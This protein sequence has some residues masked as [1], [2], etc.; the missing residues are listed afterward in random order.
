M[1]LLFTHQNSARLHYIFEDILSMR[2]SVDVKITNDWS[3][4]QA[5]TNCTKIIYTDNQLVNESGGHDLWI[6]NSGFL[7][8]SFIRPWGDYPS[9]GSLKCNQNVTSI[10]L[11]SLPFETI[12]ALFLAKKP[13]TSLTFETFSEE[14]TTNSIPFDALAEIFWCLSRYEEVQWQ[15]FQNNPETKNSFVSDKHGRFPAQQS[16]F[17]QL[18]WLQT[19]VIDKLIYLIGN[20]LKIV[21][22]NA[23]RIVP[24][25]D[26][27]MAL[28]YG[29]RD[30]ITTLGSIVKDLFCRPRLISERLL[31]I[32]SKKDPY[33][34][35]RWALP[36]LLKSEHYKIFLLLSKSRSIRNKQISPRKMTAELQRV[37][38][39]FAPHQR[40]WGI[41]PSWQEK[42][43]AML[44]Q[45]IWRDELETFE[46]NTGFVAQHAR[47]HY[48]HLHIPHS[49]QLLEKMG[50]KNDW[51]MG[52]PDEIGFR[53]GTSIAYT[54]YD[55]TREKSSG[56]MVHPF[57]IMDV[58]CNFYKK[59]TP[60]E[61]ID[62]THLMKQSLEAIG[63]TFCFVFHN[64]SVSESYPW[65]GWKVVVESWFVQ[66]HMNQKKP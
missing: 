28:R 30:K 5:Q 18:N 44:N 48:I 35:D 6:F 55:L 47:F 50:I 13:E 29:G 2:L 15:I 25:A 51:S 4:F 46:L 53:A 23:F 37:F 58:T 34:I 63:G 56:L 17:Y 1:V 45:T 22:K 11:K 57:C 31:T 49:Y 33:Q 24:T 9:H 61:T 12:E 62:L 39:Q 38:K 32:L 65:K 42:S 16:F 59:L 66:P 41:H 43:N 60:Q 7:G 54:W 8:E 27:D 40:H 52:Y 19:P 64:E 20:L 26:I 3:F 10:E 36:M 21:P 14:L